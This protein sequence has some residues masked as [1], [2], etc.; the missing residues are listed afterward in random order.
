MKFRRNLQMVNV[1]NISSTTPGSQ[2]QFEKK[3][4]I[5]N[6]KHSVFY[7][8]YQRYIFQISGI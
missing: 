7:E 3:K 8:N 6:K 4:Y 1:P 5:E 2:T